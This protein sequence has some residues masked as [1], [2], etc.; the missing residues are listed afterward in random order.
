MILLYFSLGSMII[1][2]YFF[3]RSM[4]IDRYLLSGLLY[5][6]PLRCVA[7]LYT[8]ALMGQLLLAPTATIDHIHFLLFT[9][10]LFKRIH[11]CYIH[12]GYQQM[13]IM[14]TLICNHTFQVHHMPHHRVFAGNAHPA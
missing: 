12:A 4:V 10:H 14:G 8:G 9:F 5:R 3:M 1:D 11:P 7:L 13:N 2:P 6:W